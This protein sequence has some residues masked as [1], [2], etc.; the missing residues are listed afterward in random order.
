MLFRD[1]SCP[2][3]VFLQSWLRKKY[4][5]HITPRHS[6]HNQKYGYVITG[7]WGKENR[8]I[9]KSYDFQNYN[10]YEE[11]LEAGLQEGLKLINKDDK[12][13]I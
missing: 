13:E 6:P 9:I 4:N 10:S 8:G 12:K 7:E 3:Y 2:K 11:A 5:I 1:C